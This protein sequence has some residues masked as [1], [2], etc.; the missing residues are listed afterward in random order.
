MPGEM[1]SQPLSYGSTLGNVFPIES[2]D[3]SDKGNV[4]NR[5][6]YIESLARP[7]RYV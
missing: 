5:E 1:W 7:T 4:A 6:N 2:Y 3:T